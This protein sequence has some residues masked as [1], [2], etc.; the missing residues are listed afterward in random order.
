[1]K[2]TLSL[3]FLFI[4]FGTSLFC[5]TFTFRANHMTGGRATGKEVMILTGAAEVQ[6]DNLNLYADRIEILGEDNQ[7]V[8]C[9]GNVRGRDDE[10]GIIFYTD[11][12]RYDRKLKIARLE[13]N[14]T[15]ED[16]KNEVVA[17]GR[18]IEYNDET[19]IAIIQVSVRLFKD[20]M[21]CRSEYA[22]YRREEKTL[23]LSG[24]P[25]V[26]KNNDEFRAEKMQVD[27]DTEDVIMEGDVSGT[28][29]E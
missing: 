4:I 1:M 27:L 7:F 13:G 5:D 2:R 28:I 25:V 14:S 29:K 15:M 24:F 20:K 26:Y 21:V 10:Q 11:R 12:L 19:E 16:T 18:F 8:E 3:C 22:L 9:I 17:K 23:D 6:S